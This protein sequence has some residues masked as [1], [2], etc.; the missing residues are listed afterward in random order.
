MAPEKVTVE[1]APCKDVAEDG[2]TVDVA[3]RI[4]L[5][6]GD[7]E[8]RQPTDFVCLI[9]A[10]G[11]MGAAAINDNCGP[12]VKDDGYSVLDIVKHAVNSVM[13]MLTD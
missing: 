10:S 4:R 13:H 5:P 7:A 9:D 12:G 2:A 6:D 3:V 8:R 1:I 11:S